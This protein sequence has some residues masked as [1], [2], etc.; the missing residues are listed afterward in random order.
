MTTTSNFNKFISEQVPLA[1]ILSLLL[2]IH[3]F[4]SIALITF[5]VAIVIYIVKKYN[6]NVPLFISFILFVFAILTAIFEIK[7]FAE[8]LAMYGYYFLTITVILNLT[9]YFKGGKN[10]AN[11]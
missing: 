2:I 6:S 1:I 10:E 9:E 8:Q 7:L 4:N 5:F 11:N 3:F